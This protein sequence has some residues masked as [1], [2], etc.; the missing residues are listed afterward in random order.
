MMIEYAFIQTI[1]GQ[2]KWNGKFT[3]LVKEK[4]W[5]TEKETELCGNRPISILNY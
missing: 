2:T 3:G 1:K 4:S 5:K